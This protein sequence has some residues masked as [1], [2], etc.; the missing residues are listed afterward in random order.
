MLFYT[1]EQYE[2]ALT[3]LATQS[4]A[5]REYARNVGVAHSNLAWILTDYDTWEKNPYYV[6]PPVPHP[7]EDADSHYED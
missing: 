2:E 6:G 3:P 1:E 4:D 5:C 7:E